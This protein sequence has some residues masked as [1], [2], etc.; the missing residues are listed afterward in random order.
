MP[1]LPFRSEDDDQAFAA[2]IKR[3]YETLIKDTP[4]APLP[5]RPQPT[6][7]PT[8]PVQPTPAPLAEPK[9]PKETFNYEQYAEIAKQSYQDTAKR[10][11]T[12]KHTY[13]PDLSTQDLA[14]FENENEHVVGV[15]GTSKKAGLRDFVRDAAVALGSVSTLSGLNVLQSG[16]DDVSELVEKLK[17]R[18]P[19]KR[20]H[21]T[22]HS[23]GGSIA[24]F[25]GIDNQDVDVTTFN[26]GTGLPFLTDVVK[27]SIRGCG[28]IKN[29]R[30]SGD[31]ASIGSKFDRTGETVSLK[32][33]R[34]TAE[35]QEAAQLAEGYLIGKDLF[36]PHGISQFLG[37]EHR[38]K[39]DP[40][41]YSRIL[42]QKTGRTLGAIL[43][44][45]AQAATT[46]LAPYFLSPSQIQSRVALLPEW[47]E[48]SLQDL[49]TFAR[50]LGINPEGP[51][52]QR[53]SWINPL[54]R[55]ARKPVLNE[56][57]GELELVDA[58]ADLSSLLGQNVGTQTGIA[59]Q[60]GLAGLGVQV[61]EVAGLA[62]YE[63]L[64]ASDK[65]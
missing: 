49:K 52:N 29:F 65:P 40:N 4:S 38:A 55:T 16:I 32:P 63:A 27:C 14:V 31:F 1:P 64:L 9:P 11:N 42:A 33:V 46:R 39:L 18:D 22:G 7:P 59:T 8:P 35:E 51:A 12:S 23:L 3:S 61:G 30:I 26:K 45:A 53:I 17:K 2:Q 54:A 34:P 6:Q 20:V 62:A 13:L 57:L 41:I 44:L 21:L 58:T 10:E 24:S 47:S 37:R 50:D 60:A 48:A 5:P 43:P 25:Y 36:L 19:E 28:N 56:A 15:R